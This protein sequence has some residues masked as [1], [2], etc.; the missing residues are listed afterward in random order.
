MLNSVKNAGLDKGKNSL[1]AN[2]G[3]T[4]PS[5]ATLGSTQM[6]ADSTSLPGETASIAQSDVDNGK[7]GGNNIAVVPP[8]G[9]EPESDPDPFDPEY[10]RLDP[11]CQENGPP[12]IA[13]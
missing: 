2:G 13:S 4:V 7:R 5:T 12:R 11:N 8:S 1:P 3:E 9:S 10:L 6:A